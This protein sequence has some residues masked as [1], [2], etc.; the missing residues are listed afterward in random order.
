M[1]NKKRGLGD[2]TVKEMRALNTQ[3]KKMIKV[4]KFALI[5]HPGKIL[6]FQF[7]VGLVRGVGSFI[8]A[9][10]VIGVLIYILS[11]LGY[12]EVLRDLNALRSI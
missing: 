9:T 5:E 11:T 1:K 10:I 12:S 2:R 6:G 8:G 4:H 3:I 7:L